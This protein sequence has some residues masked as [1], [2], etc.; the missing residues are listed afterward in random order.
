M[1]EPASMQPNDVDAQ[2]S[3]DASIMNVSASE[4]AQ[5]ESLQQ[6]DLLQGFPAL[7]DALILPE[8]EPVDVHRQLAQ[9]G[10]AVSGGAG[11]VG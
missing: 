9:S 7:R 5:Q 6:P 11:S 1:R 8:P 10:G 4:P 3:T 2:N